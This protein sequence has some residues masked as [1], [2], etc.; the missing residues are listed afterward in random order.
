M[1]RR[2]DDLDR[3][4]IDLLKTEAQQTSEKLGRKLRVSSATVRRRTRKLIQ[5]RIIKIVATADSRRLGYPLKVIIAFDVDHDQ[6][7][8][9]TRTLNRDPEIEWVCTTAGR[10][11]IVASG[12]FADTERLSEYLRGRASEIQGIRN[13][14]TFLCLQMGKGT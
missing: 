5:N 14:E 9:V 8:A 12:H 13:S 7:E 6:L 1:D 3:K 10:Y 2:I 11:D 4:L